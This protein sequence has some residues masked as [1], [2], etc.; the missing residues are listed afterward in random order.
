MGSDSSLAGI[1]ARNNDSLMKLF[2]E[3]NAPS[4][5]AL[6]TEDAQFLIPN[7]DPVRGRAAIEGIWKMLSSHGHTLRVETLELEG[8]DTTAI[9]I[10]QFSRTD[11]SGA[12]MDRGKYIV[13]W[14]KQGPEWK[15]HRDMISSSLPKAS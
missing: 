6:Y 1:I 9:E 10:G 7:M 12:L 8:T 2:L 3:G 13:I 15:I 11:P 5:G 14:K 4:L